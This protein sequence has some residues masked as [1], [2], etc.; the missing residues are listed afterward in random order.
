MN[1]LFVTLCR[2]HRVRWSG[3]RTCKFAIWLALISFH[4]GA[5]THYAIVD[6]ETAGEYTLLVELGNERGWNQESEIRLAFDMIDEANLAYVKMKDG[7][8]ALFVVKGNVEK[9]VA[10]PRPFPAT[11]S[12]TIFLQRRYGFV[13]LIAGQQLVLNAAWNQPIAGRVGTWT[14]GG[15]SLAEVYIQPY[16]DP[17]M[18]DDFTRG[19][20]EADSWELYAGTWHNTLVSA[21]NAD[22][23]RSANPF[24]FRAIAEP[25]A[26]AITTEAWCWDDYRV[27]VN[28]RPLDAHA[29]GVAAYVQDGKN[30]I[31]F[32]WR[33]GKAQLPRA[34]Q[35]VLLQDGKEKLLAET[36]GGF[37]ANQ[38]YRLDLQIVAGKIQASID[39]YPVLAAESDA[40]GQGR[41]ALLCQAGTA[42]FDDVAVRAADSNPDNQP[43]INPVFL[44]DEVMAA[45]ELYT[46]IGEWRPPVEGVRWH[47]GY[48]PGEVCVRVPAAVLTE[49]PLGVLLRGDG[50]S[51]E[52][53]YVIQLT[54]QNGVVK[55]TLV[56]AGAQTTTGDGEVPDDDVVTVEATGATVQV[57]TR[58]QD[59]LAFTDPTP[60]QGKMLGLLNPSVE[61][62]T[63]LSVSSPLFL[64][65]TFGAAPTDWFGSKGLWHVTTRWPCQPGW[66]FFGGTHDE[67]PTLWTKH[68]YEGDVLL[69]CFAN[70]QMDAPPPPGYTHPSDICLALCGDGV[71]LGSGY[72][73]VFAG[74]KNT[75]TVIFRQGRIVAESATALFVNP[76]SS[77]PEFHR[78][79]FRVRAEKIGGRI[80]FSVDGR[81]IL[82]YQDPDPLLGGRAAIWTFHNGIMIGRVRLWFAQERPGGVLPG[83][84]EPEPAPQAHLRT[85]DAAILTDFET[86]V[87]E[88]QTFSQP[89]SVELA[90]DTSTKASGHRSL[91]IRNCV[92]G[93]SLGVYAS[94]T[95]FR[96]V[97]WPKLSF[98]YRVP[99][100]IATNIYVYAS[101]QWHAIQFTAEEPTVS[102]TPLLGT[103]PDVKCDDSWHHAEFDLHTPLATMHP[104]SKVLEVKYVAFAAPEESYVRCGIG[105]NHRGATYWIDNF[106]IGP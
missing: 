74:W 36:H 82:S 67:N 106:R 40:F 31:L 59:L 95:P 29:V 71:N 5:S 86:D 92:S 101:R 15:V 28:V 56:R 105:G 47:W 22:P 24:A 27:S 13:R 96:A 100:G 69:E 90:L 60:L 91:R 80:G 42:A 8:A 103:I 70:I 45:N 94:V 63:Q 52:N 43:W 37:L 46:P 44:A 19:P 39:R 17:F 32:R 16:A 9:M 51:A 35:L 65:D 57:M 89:P 78:H 76:T 2:L 41:V 34:K 49:T 87:G 61:Q 85:P 88:W 12:R 30:M 79:W 23:A 104:E 21:P 33:A 55:A 6:D 93:G 84:L 48:Y 77:N 7:R 73:F 26:L 81:E 53:G 75:K 50:S 38:W 99:P 14:S 68:N 11:V 18:N 97:E 4:A 1:A 25:E 3:P 62:L 66:T 58:K 20:D 64:D 98:D 72:A 10:E 54:R 83:R 102:A